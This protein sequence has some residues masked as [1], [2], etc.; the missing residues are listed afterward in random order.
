MPIG[1]KT[2]L[3]S[4]LNSAHMV[5]MMEENEDGDRPRGTP[6]SRL[7]RAAQGAKRQREKRA[8]SKRCHTGKRTFYKSTVIQHVFR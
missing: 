7:T 2:A 8:G 3:P 1:A 5:Q 6:D 4:P